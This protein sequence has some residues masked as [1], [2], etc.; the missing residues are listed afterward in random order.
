[1][2]RKI[3][4]LSF[5]LGVTKDWKSKWFSSK[6]YKEYLQQDIELRSFI[7]KKLSKAAVKEVVIERSANSVSVIIYSARPGII[8]GR[9][10][11]GIEDLKN[12]I[13]NKFFSKGKK[14]EFKIEIQEVRSPET[15]AALVAQNIAEQLER[16]IPFRRVLKQTID[17]VIQHKEVEG[18]RVA[19]SGRLGG[20]EMARRQWLAKG[21]IPLQTLRANVDFA[22]TNAYTTYGVIGVKVWINKGEI[23]L[24]EQEGKKS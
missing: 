8:I 23:F 3:N 6:K 1:M 19:V 20:T 21:K 2:G 7:A 22:Q 24:K 15:Q 5:R 12:Q 13:K 16:R 10:G 14:I 9:G 11:T 18:V 4:P 17:K